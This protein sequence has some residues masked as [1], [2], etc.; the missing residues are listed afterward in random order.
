[1]VLKDR[2]GVIKG[3]K[4]IRAML[5]SSE[6][7]VSSEV[8]FRLNWKEERIAAAGFSI[9]TQFLNVLII[10]CERVEDC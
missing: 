2:A 6:T 7:F 1:M 5:F 4:W 8:V 9:S 3:R 10:Y